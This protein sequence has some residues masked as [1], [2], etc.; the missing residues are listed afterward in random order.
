MRVKFFEGVG[1]GINHEIA[2][3]I[4]QEIIHIIEKNSFTS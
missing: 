1:H 3:Q 2:E 4:N